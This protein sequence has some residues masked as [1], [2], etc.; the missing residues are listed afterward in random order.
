MGKPETYNKIK[1][2]QLPGDLSPEAQR[3]HSGFKKIH[4]RKRRQQMKRRTQSDIERE[5]ESQEE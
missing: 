2:G 5:L 3:E 4:A 1:V